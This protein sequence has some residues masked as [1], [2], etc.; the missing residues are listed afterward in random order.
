M[1]STT[2]SLEYYSKFLLRSV[3]FWQKH[4]FEIVSRHQKMKKNLFLNGK[5]HS[6]KYVL[7]FCFDF[8]NLRTGPVKASCSGL[9]SVEFGLNIFTPTLSLSKDRESTALLGNLFQ[10]SMPK[11]SW[12]LRPL[13][14]ILKT[15]YWQ[16]F[17][18]TWEAFI[19]HSIFVNNIWSYR[20]FF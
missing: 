7:Y 15:F 9:Y 16:L 11:A 17:Q 6:L 8:D 5:P 10:G 3:I 2:Q 19:T 18:I 4:T 14:N 12:C 1:L 20:G 13:Q